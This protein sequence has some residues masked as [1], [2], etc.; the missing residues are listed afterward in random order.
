MKEPECGASAGVELGRIIAGQGHAPVV[1]FARIGAEHVKIG[2]TTNLAARMQTFYLGLRDVLL[3]VPGGH[4]VESGYHSRFRALGVGGSR[5]ELFRFAG[6]L[7]VFLTNP[8][9]RDL[10]EYLTRRNDREPE[11]R[12]AGPVELALTSPLPLPLNCVTI[13]ESA[14]AGMLPRAWTKPGG[15]FRTAKSR[16]K[17]DGIPVPDVKGTRGTRALYDADAL[18]DFIE[19]ITATKE[20]SS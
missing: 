5:R 17:K 8:A 9:S 1:Y 15:A 10:A 2:T 7:E 12:V 3:I 6:D 19:T 11:V 20:R 13:L 14:A 18:A 4:V 16:A